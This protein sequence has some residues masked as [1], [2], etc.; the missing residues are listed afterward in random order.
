M[1]PAAARGDG[2]LRRIDRWLSPGAR[3]EEATDERVCARCFYAFPGGT[4]GTPR[5][6][7][8]CGASLDPAIAG[9]L[10]APGPSASARWFMHA[11]GIWHQ[12]AVLGA[13][14]L[15]FIGDMA[16]GGWFTTLLIGALALLGLGAF[17]AARIIIATILAIRCGRLRTVDSQPGWWLPPAMVMALALLIALGVPRWAGFRIQHPRLQAARTA[18]EALPPDQRAK[19]D[20]GAM[21]LWTPNGLRDAHPAYGLRYSG[22]GFAVAVP[23]TG[24]LFEMGTYAYL[25]E[26]GAEEARGAGL[27]A[28][29]D[30]W[31]EGTFDAMD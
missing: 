2:R 23:S 1:T 6:C 19:G 21:L 9:T 20:P 18:W 26:I 14:A 11:P 22:P 29:G 3:L 10:V 28:L 15:L 25:P 30:G 16:P 7:T 13:C 4:G 5:A 31:Y 8:E 24:F 17:G 27:R 12:V